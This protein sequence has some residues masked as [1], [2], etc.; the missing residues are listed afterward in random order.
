VLEDPQVEVLRSQLDK[1]HAET[2][3]LQEKLDQLRQ[4]SRAQALELESARG[5][6]ASLQA[7]REEDRTREVKPPAPAKAT[8]DTGK[9]EGELKA[10]AERHMKVEKELRSANRALEKALEEERARNTPSRPAP[11]QVSV[12]TPEAGSGSKKAAKAD[13]PSKANVDDQIA[14]AVQTAAAQFEKRIR[15]Q[16]R[17]IERLKR[18]LEAEAARITGPESSPPRIETPP[19]REKPVKQATPVPEIEPAPAPKRPAK[20]KQDPD[21]ELQERVEELEH[22]NESLREQVR[23]LH[24]KLKEVGGKE[25]VQEVMERIKLT[26]PTSRK[27]R[28]Q[29]A[30]E[31]L[32]EDAQRRII[33][34]RMREQKVRELEQRELMEAIKKVK[35]RRNL[36]QVEMLGHLQKAAEATRARFHDALANYHDRNRTPP[37]RQGESP[38]AL[39]ADGDAAPGGAVGDAATEAYT[40][41]ASSAQRH[42][43][44][45]GRWLWHEDPAVVS[46]RLAQLRD[47]NQALLAEVQRLRMLQ[48]SGPE[49]FGLQSRPILGR[50]ER[51]SHATGSSPSSGSGSSGAM[52]QTSMA[53]SYSP[54]PG[55]PGP[56]F[57]VLHKS[58][59]PV[60]SAPGNAGHVSASRGSPS[61]VPGLVAQA[62][63]RRVSSPESL[64][65]PGSPAPV[66]RPHSPERSVSVPSLGFSS[67]AAIQGAAQRG[68]RAPSAQAQGP[69]PLLGGSEPPW[70]HSSTPGEKGA[71]GAALDAAGPTPPAELGP[72]ANPVP[73]G[74]ATRG[75]GPTWMPN[76]PGRVP[77]TSP[78]EPIRSS[79]G[80]ASPGSPRGQR[81]PAEDGPALSLSGVAGTAPQD[82]SLP[83][84]ATHGWGAPRPSKSRKGSAF[85]AAT[86]ALVDE[87]KPMRGFCVTPLR[88]QESMVALN[89]GI[90][91]WAAEPKLTG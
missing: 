49:S 37:Q 44:Q 84:D 64:L 90:P 62:H 4:E 41:G 59:S 57:G 78:L 56:S 35:D 34:M 86:A 19:P 75:P 65:G 63:Q 60:L 26:V 43:A 7:A 82:A 39:E 80:P 31:R 24:D 30:F 83:S 66:Q 42:Q 5:N 77:S 40:R 22:E 8:I 45:E 54:Q 81:Q 48:P 27:K 91:K 15:E 71:A 55:L 25:A 20:P 3:A 12:E 67:A 32:Y 51:A 73:P 21:E 17:E 23:M 87:P 29:K 72:A 33:E 2:R 18:E 10:Q 89:G 13:K 47:E 28:K 50:A 1:A 6:L 16:E 53:T 85:A 52:R 14:R 9:L 38:D 69:V 58:R 70:R 74:Q 68:Q 79:M 76:V 46:G 61:A 36:H 88:S 11:A